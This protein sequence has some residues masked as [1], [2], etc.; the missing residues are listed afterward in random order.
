MDWSRAGSS[1]L[2]KGPHGVNCPLAEQ[3]NIALLGA[4]GSICELFANVPQAQTKPTLASALKAELGEIRHES[5]RRTQ[6][7]MYAHATSCTFFFGRSG[8]EMETESNYTETWSIRI[9]RL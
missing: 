9:R 5:Y 7:T 4:I 1:C 3:E 2:E 8:F 6:S